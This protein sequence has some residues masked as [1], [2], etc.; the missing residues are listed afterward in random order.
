MQNA[1]T[2]GYIAGSTVAR[3]AEDLLL[4]GADYDLAEEGL[5]TAVHKV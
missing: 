5:Q 3:C 2:G 1:W 4:A